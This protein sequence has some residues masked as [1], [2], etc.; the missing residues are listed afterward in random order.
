[1]KLNYKNPYFLLAIL[2][3]VW[4]S[5]FMLMKEGLKTFSSF[6]VAAYRITLAGLALLPF[7]RWKKIQIKKGDFKYFALSGILGSGI[8]AF[9]FTAAQTK[10]SSSLAGALNS[11]TPIFT[12]FI[13]VAFLGV[14]YHK[15]NIVGVFVGIAGAFFLIFQKGVMFEW[16]HALLAV[17]ATLFYGTN[18]NLIK[19]KLSAYPSLLVAALPLAVI[20]AIGFL[21]LLF[22]HPHPIWTDFQ[23][24]KSFSAIVV[25]A[26]VGTAISLIFF[27]N[28]IQQTSAVFASSVTYLIPIVAMTW[29]FFMQEVITIYQIV[30][31]TLILVA[32]WLI[33]FKKTSVKISAN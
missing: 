12:L 29:G 23:T 5:S 32:I 1:M 8:P 9:L 18:V 11:L 6:E 30:G 20:S 14:S 2:A 3:I 17:L 24:L 25:L 4:G 16:S 10:I 28:L 31:L 15:F 21:L 19:H 7:V 26:V 27:N 13:G 33:R 22:L